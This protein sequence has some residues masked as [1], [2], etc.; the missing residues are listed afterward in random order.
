MDDTAEFERDK[1]AWAASMAADP[2]MRKLA[3]ETLIAAD[4]HNFCYQWSWLGMPIIQPAEDILALQE[5][6]WKAKPSL[7]IE[8]GVAR[9]G[10]VIFSASLLKLL[11]KGRVIG[12]DIDIRQHNRTRIEAH[13]CGD[14]VTLLQGSSIE[15]SMLEAVTAEIAPDDA[16]MVVL[17]SN[18]TDE[19][20]FAEL[21]LYAK[22]VSIGQYLVVADTLVDIIPPQMHRQR[23]WGPG[24]N[25]MTALMRFLKTHPEFEIDQEIDNKLLL[26]T[27]PKGYVKRIA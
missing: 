11:G 2:A 9:G 6:I 21:E 22:L 8:T 17:D 12:I 4:E 25:P 14:R 15:A 19:H 1:R 26:T 20:V 23:P 27:N 18:H 16:V 10:S 24:D 13:P 7:I 3:L 5:I